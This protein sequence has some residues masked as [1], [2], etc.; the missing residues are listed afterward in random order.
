[1]RAGSILSKMGRYVEVFRSTPTEEDWGALSRLVAFQVL[2]S[3]LF[4]QFP[5]L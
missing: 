4:R 1:M 3:I 5:P 2:P